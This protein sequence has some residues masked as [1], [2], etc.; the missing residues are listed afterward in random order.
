ME[1][2]ERGN[3][4]GKEWPKK[5]SVLSARILFWGTTIEDL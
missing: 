1:H 4:I 2:P 3:P 5:G